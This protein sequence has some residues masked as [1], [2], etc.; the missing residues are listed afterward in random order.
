MQQN[1]KHALKQG[2]VVI[3]LFMKLPSADLVEIF[4]EAVCDFIIVDQEHGPLRMES[5]SNLV[6]SCDLM[7]MAA[8][9]SIPEN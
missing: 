9:I 1:L 4:G 3:G 6:R 5:V 7:G 2:Q 8:I